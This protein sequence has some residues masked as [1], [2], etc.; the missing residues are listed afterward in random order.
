MQTLFSKNNI[1]LFFLIFNSTFWY[2]Y[3]TSNHWVNGYGTEK[4][5]WF[6]MIDVFISTPLICFYFLGKNRKQALIKSLAYM[7]ILTLLGSY[8]IPTEE[9]HLW[10]YLENLR[11]V[12]IIA[13]VIFELFIITTVVFAIKSA[14]KH[15]KDLDFAISEPLEKRMGKSIFTQ[16]M[17]FDIRLW[18][19]VLFP[20]KINSDNYVGDQQFYGNLKDGTQSFLQGFVFIILFEIPLLHLLLHF[21]WSPLAANVITGLTAFSLAYFIAEYRAIAKRPISLD[22]DYLIIRYGLSNPLKIKLTDIKNVT[23]NKQ[24]IY[25]S[26]TSKRYNLV[27]IPNIEIIVENNSFDKI[28]LGLNNPSG[29]IAK[30]NQND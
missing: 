26:P 18:S 2:F 1:P 13:V 22:K 7:G 29:F 20:S 25:R 19:F 11:F 15:N 28:Y 21:I 17:Q 27:G 6:L 16:L 30:F 24:T 23:L 8:I 4:F 3:Y 14:F 5:E 12:G 9:K 10:I